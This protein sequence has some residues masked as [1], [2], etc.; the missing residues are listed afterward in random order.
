MKG[1]VVHTRDSALRVHNEFSAAMMTSSA[2]PFDTS[3]VQDFVS[4]RNEVQACIQLIN[5]ATATVSHLLDESKQAFDPEK[6][7]EISGNLRRCTV[8]A[9]TSAR[10]AQ[11][12]RGCRGT[13]V[14]SFVH[15]SRLRVLLSVQG[16]INKMK[17]QCQEIARLHGSEDRTYQYVAPPLLLFGRRQRVL[18]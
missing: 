11:V 13:V 16:L 2:R 8:T 10:I 1:R 5:S 9:A 14:R 18:L 17:T 4:D 6:D 7:M 15:H 12:S 3:A